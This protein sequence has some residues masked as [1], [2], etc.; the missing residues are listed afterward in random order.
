MA[1]FLNHFPAAWAV[2][3]MLA[4]T[5]LFPY[6]FRYQREALTS[7]R[8]FMSDRLKGVIEER[9]CYREQLHTERDEHNTTLLRCKE[10][11]MRP[12]LSDV[13]NVLEEQ[14][15]VL[16]GI[17]DAFEA[18]SKE[19]AQVFTKIIAVLERLEKK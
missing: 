2:I 9:N 3:G 16:K 4:T 13:K 11:E 6:I 15:R 5:A 14:S 8:E 7:Y 18:H 12:D 17:M 19:D 1:D 10:L